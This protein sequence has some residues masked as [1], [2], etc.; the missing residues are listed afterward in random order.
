MSSITIIAANCIRETLRQRL[1]YN[2]VIFGVGM[3]IFAMVVSDITFGFP[4]RVVRSIGLSGVSIALN[5]MALLLG[6]SMVH[7]EIERKTLFV[8]LTRPIERWQYVVGRYLGLVCAL[9]AV[10]VGFG[11]MF[12]LMLLYVMG[13][14]NVQDIIALSANVVEACVIGAFALALSCFSTP[15]LSAGIGLGFWV[16]CASADNLLNLS[17]NSET[18]TKVLVT[19]LSWILPNFHQFNYREAAIY[20]DTIPWIEILSTFMYGGIYII[21]F[22]ALASAILSRREMV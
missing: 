4:D 17:Q 3:M 10:S 19:I 22:V 20:S 1:F 18:S 14:P 6:V 12:I 5:L 13:T 9:T 16:A 11:L 21:G 15:S 7:R 2:I 8:V